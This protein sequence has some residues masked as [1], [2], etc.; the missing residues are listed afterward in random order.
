MKVEISGEF[1]ASS[2]HG[3]SSYDFIAGKPE[4]YLGLDG[5]LTSAALYSTICTNINPGILRAAYNLSLGWGSLWE[6]CRGSASAPTYFKPAEV[7]S[8]DGQLK[9]V[10]IDGGA[11]QNNPVSM[12][13]RSFISAVLAVIM[14]FLQCTS[15]NQEQFCALNNFLFFPCRWHISVVVASSYLAENSSIT[16]DIYFLF[17]MSDEYENFIVSH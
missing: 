6:V 11:I 7:N 2:L 9:T 5:F 8:V 1:T 12:V 3:L 14:F 15:K 16:I 13:F 10:L 17:S 4:N